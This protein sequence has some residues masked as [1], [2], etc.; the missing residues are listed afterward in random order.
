MACFNFNPFGNQAL[1]VK[2]TCDQCEE[3]IISEEIGIPKP[4]YAADTASESQTDSEGYAF[5]ENCDKEFNISIYV[6]YAG[7]DGH[8]EELP[9]IDN[10][11]IG[12]EEIPE[13]LDEYYEE[14]IDAILSSAYYDFFFFDEIEKLKALNDIDLENEEL[15]E[16]LRRQIFSAAITCLED[17]LST[18]L[19]QNILN[20]EENFKQFVKT[21]QNIKNRKFDLS[22]IY[23]KLN[24]IRDIVKK[25]LVEV[26]YHNLPKV[27]GMY[28]DTLGIDFPNIDELMKV[29]KTRQDM[30][31]F[32]KM[33]KIKKVKKLKSPK[34]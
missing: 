31:W 30:I 5:C 4:N 6:T 16:T 8:I 28:H 14:Q 20:D 1:I 3:Q 32:T 18:T 2:F 26:I 11:P 17:Y 9:E 12:V 10:I 15:Q 23:D 21:F 29:I 19:I 25:E 13:K 7:G 34:S 33:E 22:E 24:S 27:K